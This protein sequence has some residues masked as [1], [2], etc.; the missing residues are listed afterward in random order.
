M[1]EVKPGQ[2][3]EHKNMG[4]RVEITGPGDA[5]GMWKWVPASGQRG[6]YGET[7][8]YIL[9]ADYVLVKEAP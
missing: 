1:S 5:I 7:S 9:L 2:V 4:R 3:W 6:V 8:E